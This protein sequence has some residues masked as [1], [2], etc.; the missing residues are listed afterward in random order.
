M[1]IMALVG[2]P[3]ASC[4]EALMRLGLTTTPR[5]EFL[6]ARCDGLGFGICVANPGPHDHDHDDGQYNFSIGTIDESKPLPP[7]G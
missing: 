2:H 3:E 5:L 6:H 1:M 4:R 7:G